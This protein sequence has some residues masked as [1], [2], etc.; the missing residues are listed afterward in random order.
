MAI[1]RKTVIVLLSIV[2]GIAI[3]AALL[4]TVLVNPDRYRPQVISFLE[5]KTGKKIEIGRIEVSWI[6][7]S[8]R[9]YEFGVRN[10]EP[11]PSGYFLK[12]ER[13]DAAIDLTALL[14]RQISVKS[15]VVHNP[16]IDVISDPDGLWN[17]E[18]PPTKAGSS[19]PILA[20]GTIPQVTITGGHL[21]GSS[22]IDPS[23]RPG[24][25]VFEVGNLGV[26]LIDVNFNAFTG[27]EFSPVGKGELSA[28][29]LRLGSIEVTKVKSK[30]RLTAKAVFFDNAS[31]AADGGRATGTLSFKLAGK[32]PRFETSVRL[33]DI[34]VRQLLTRFPDARGKMSG[35]MDG[36]VVVGG[37]I[38]HTLNPLLG[39]RG[40]GKFTIRDGEFP[41]LN[42]N[43]NLKQL[44]RFRDSQDESRPLSSFSS[45]SSDLELADQQMTS[46]EI[47]IALYGVD[48]QCA[49][50]LDLRGA[51][52]L[53]YDGAVRVMK[54]QGFFTNVFARAFREAR[55]ENGKLVFPIRITG[56]LEE[57]KVAVVD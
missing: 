23:D 19:S 36:E 24:P 16:T 47:K 55:E 11:F 56:T 35:T 49:G 31:V 28:D 8:I 2:A 48:M 6:P 37:R 25:V 5:S 14:R 32:T 52:T 9:L 30:L 18:N 50:E 1:R 46:R 15:V 10:P 54:K 12:A 7:T 57:P 39:I 38:E 22:L 13:I 20:I 45:I 41:S 43:D 34:D 53:N 51:G 17:F 42:T 29:S 21:L 27:P 4:F 40:T 33:N 26:T 3:A 44:A